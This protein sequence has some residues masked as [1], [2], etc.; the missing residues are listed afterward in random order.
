MHS[1]LNKVVNGICKVEQLFQMLAFSMDLLITSKRMDF[2]GLGSTTK[3]AI[4][5]LY[6]RLCHLCEIFTQQ[7]CLNTS[8]NC[9]DVNRYCCHGHFIFIHIPPYLQLL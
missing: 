1:L 7:L 5:V 4:G 9:P 6:A 8:L 2:A 3:T